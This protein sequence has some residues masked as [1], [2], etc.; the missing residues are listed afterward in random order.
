MQPNR[1]HMLLLEV[2]IAFSLLLLCLIP[3]IQ[4]HLVMIQSEHEF[5]HEV[6]LDRLVNELYA[7]L[8]VK[9][10]YNQRISWDAIA[11]KREIP[12]ASEAVQDL[13]FQ[14]SYTI[15]HLA[16]SG[17]ALNEN[18]PFHLLNIQYKFSPKIAKK[19]K[20]LEYNFQLFVQREKQQPAAPEQKN[21]KPA[22]IKPSE[23]PKP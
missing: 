20:V 13:G 5:I 14:G 3:L 11:S 16:P 4:P 6:Q 12:L 18:Q 22:A 21:Q 15:T 1:Q 10:F 19:T 7:D 23:G 17:G 9:D 2:L 8:L